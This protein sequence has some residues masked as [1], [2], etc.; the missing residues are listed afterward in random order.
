MQKFC[1]KCALNFALKGEKIEEMPDD[2]G[3]LNLII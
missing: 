3:K 1:S 2:G